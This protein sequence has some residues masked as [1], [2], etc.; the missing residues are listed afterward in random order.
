MATIQNIN[1]D[2]L[3]KDS[4]T[5]IN[6]NFWSLNTELGEKANSTDI[7]DNTDYVDLTTAQSIDW[8]KT[9]SW[10]L[11]KTEAEHSITATSWTI[12]LNYAN[13]TYQKITLTWT[14]TFTLSNPNRNFLTLKITNW[15][16]Q[17]ITWPS[18]NWAWWTAPELSAS[19]TDIVSFYYDG[20]N[21]FWDY[22]T[23][24]ATV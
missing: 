19:W 8:D 2:E 16:A 5:K 14:T 11:K 3:I 15:W 18:V 21:Y 1:W 10:I 4:R 9:F 23:N 17:T 24:F 6:N 20:T 22:Q 13:W 12:N 7:P